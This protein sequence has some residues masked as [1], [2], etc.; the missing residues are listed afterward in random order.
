M[1]NF[2]FYNPTH[3]LASVAILRDVTTA[4]IG[5]QR[6]S[7]VQ[8]TCMSWALRNRLYGIQLYDYHLLVHGQHAKYSQGHTYPLNAEGQ[9]SLKHMGHSPSVITQL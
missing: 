1:Q 4:P 5:S 9:F 7:A 2:S 3:T 8:S 6:I